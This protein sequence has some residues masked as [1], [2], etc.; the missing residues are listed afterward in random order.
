MTSMTHN[1]AEAYV[2]VVERDS[3]TLPDGFKS[4]KAVAQS[5]YFA[6]LHITATLHCHQTIT[7]TNLHTSL[8]NY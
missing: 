3:A 5:P 7:D 2:V 4:V 1:S 6:A 8:L